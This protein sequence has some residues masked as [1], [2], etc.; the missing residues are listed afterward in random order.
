MAPYNLSLVVA[1][2]IRTRA[3]GL[4][5]ELPWPRLSEDLARFAALTRGHS[6]IMGRNTFESSEVG[7]VPL[8]GRR[9]VVLSRNAGWAP[10]PGVVHAEDWREALLL[11]DSGFGGAGYDDGAVMTEA[12]GM[13]MERNIF[14]V[15]GEEVYRCALEDGGV[16]WIFATEVEGDWDGDSFFPALESRLWRRIGAPRDGF[17][18]VLGEEFCRMGWAKDEMIWENGIAYRHVTYERATVPVMT[19]GERTQSSAAA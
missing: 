16:H 10:P 8:P 6:I 17:C 15:G 12:G 19:V 2:S 18:S 1:Y 13:G 11:A 9:N 7:G 4:L 14:V 3:I 5:G